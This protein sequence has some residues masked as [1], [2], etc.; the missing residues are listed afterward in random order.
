MVKCEECAKKLGLLEGYQHPTM[1]KKHL[2]CSNCFDQVSES[3]AKW[4][5]FVQSNS[6]NTRTS[7]YNLQLNWKKIIP[8]FT[9]I[10]DMFDNLWTEKE[11]NMER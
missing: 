6:F 3:V 4:G 10:C 1:G 8:G 11:I 9:Q 5:R 7:R 2:L